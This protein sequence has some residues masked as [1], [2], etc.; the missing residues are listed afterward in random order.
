MEFRRVLFRSR[1]DGSWSSRLAT[2][3]NLDPRHV[4]KSNVLV[5]IRMGADLESGLDLSIWS[6]NVFNKTV[7]QLDAVHN[8]LS[9]QSFQRYLSAPREL[10]VTLDRKIVV[11]GKSVSVRVDL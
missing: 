9:D 3:T 11:L 4:Q 5:N 10:G 8:I 1:I 6:N 7:V 2:N